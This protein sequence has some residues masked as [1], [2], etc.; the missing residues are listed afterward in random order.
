MERSEFCK[1]VIRRNLS[2][3]DEACSLAPAETV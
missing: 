3:E 2:N 1:V